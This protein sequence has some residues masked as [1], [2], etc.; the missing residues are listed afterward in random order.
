MGQLLQLEAWRKK[1]FAEPLPSIRSCQ[2]WA[3]NGDIPAV[4][5]GRSWFVDLEKEKR[6]TGNP[7]IDQFGG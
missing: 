5:R 7:L 2:Q 1:R 4:K 3:A 6:L